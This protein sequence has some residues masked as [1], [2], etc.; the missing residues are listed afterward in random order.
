MINY[1]LVSSKYNNYLH[2]L[3]QFQV[4]CNYANALNPVV[5]A[6]P[7]QYGGALDRLLVGHYSSDE[8]IGAG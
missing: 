5:K 8:A 7:W 6:I 3:A 2:R 1:T 4:K